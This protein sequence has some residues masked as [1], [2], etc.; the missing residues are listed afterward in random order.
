MKA[1]QQNIINLILFLALVLVVNLVSRTLFFRLD[2]TANHLYTLSDASRNVISD[3]KDPLTLRFFLSEDLPQPYSNL[4]QEIRDLMEEY[5]RK[6]NRNFNYEIVR[7]DSKGEK[8]DS[9]GE[10]LTDKA[11]RYGIRPVSVQAVGDNEMSLVNV[12]MGMVVLQGD[13]SERIANLGQETNLEYGITGIIQNIAAKTSALLAMEGNISVKLVF[14]SG[15]NRLG[16]GISTYPD[17]IKTVVDDLE[18]KYL[19]KL[20]YT[21]V[22]PSSDKTDLSRYGLNR[23]SLG[24]GG[25]EDLYA[26]LIVEKGSLFSKTELISRGL[27]GNSLKEPATRTESLQQ[28]ADRMLGVQQTVGYLTDHGAPSLY[29][30][31]YQQDAAALQ[32]FSQLLASEYSLRPVTLDTLPEGLKT[33]IIAGVTEPFSEYELFRIDQF[34]MAGG[35]LALFLDPFKQEVNQQMSFYGAPPSYTPVDTG[36]EKLLSHYGVNLQQSYLLD[37]ECYV[38]RRQQQDGS[39]SETELYFAPE[40]DPANVNR[41]VPFMGNLKGLIMLNTAPLEIPAQEGDVKRDVLFSSS[42]KAWEMKENINLTPQMITPPAEDQMKQ[43]PLAVAMSGGMTSYFDGRDIPEAPVPE[44]Q[45]DGKDSAPAARVITGGA[46][47]AGLIKE[48]RGGQIFLVGSSAILGD[49][50]LDAQGQTANSLFVLN[51]IDKI[52][53]REDYALMRSKGLSYNPVDR[54]LSS[55]TKRAIQVMNIIVLPLLVI[56]FGILMWLR[57]MGRKKKIQ[58]MFLTEEKA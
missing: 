26:A 16:Q 50:I 35:S 36:L 18:S 41:E 9:R 39:Y 47:S 40:I 54:S 55:G 12:Y 10:L 5:A 32:N 57:W 27:L 52:S 45:G 19:G 23:L 4:E 1:K 58:E 46:S 33:L 38:S 21:Y 3:L 49:N 48:N 29:G 44:A 6:G 42:A 24:E 14:S 56:L 53:G 51:G 11:S 30:N 31:Y 8:T 7:M 34:L 37:K 17:E 22:D 15:L 13:M 28:M 2:L 25:T 43:Y 20:E